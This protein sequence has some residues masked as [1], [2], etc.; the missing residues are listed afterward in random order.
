MAAADIIAAHR[1]ITIQC[2]ATLRTISLPAHRTAVITNTG[3]SAVL[4]VSFG[5]GSPVNN[6]PTAMVQADGEGAL[7]VGDEIAIRV[8]VIRHQCKAGQTSSLR[9]TFP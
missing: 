5:P 7:A 3:A 6:D 2:D 4:I 8:P 1:L 9:I